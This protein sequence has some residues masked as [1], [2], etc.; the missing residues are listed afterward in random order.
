MALKSRLHEL[1]DDTEII[2]NQRREDLELKPHNRTFKE[3]KIGKIEE[4]ACAT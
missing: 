3:A 1:S 2:Q 4:T